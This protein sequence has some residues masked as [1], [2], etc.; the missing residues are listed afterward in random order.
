MG[1]TSV[2]CSAKKA[3]NRTTSHGV[4]IRFLI[5]LLHSRMSFMVAHSRPSLR[6]I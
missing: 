3:R 2:T 1:T 6:I 5:R 4:A